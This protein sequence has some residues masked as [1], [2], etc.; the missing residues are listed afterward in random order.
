[1]VPFLKEHTLTN[2]TILKNF[3]SLSLWLYVFKFYCFRFFCFHSYML[4]LESVHLFCFSLL[5][6]LYFL[7]IPT[8]LIFSFIHYPSS[9]CN[10]TI[11]FLNSIHSPQISLIPTSLTL[12]SSP[13]SDPLCHFSAVPILMASYIPPFLPLVTNIRLHNVLSIFIP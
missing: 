6:C 2:A 9:F 12:S 13:Y 10:L 4:D 11:N 8:S 5:Q 3:D 1:M 7:L